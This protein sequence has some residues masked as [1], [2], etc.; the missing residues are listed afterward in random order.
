MSSPAGIVTP[1]ADL[2]YRNYDGPLENPDLRWWV[3]AKRMILNAIRMKSLWIVTVLSGWYFMIIMIILFFMQQLAGTSPQAASTLKSFLGRIIWKDQ[4]LHGFSFAQSLLL[5]IA[6]IFG[7]GA[8]AN[9]NRANALLVYLSKPCTKLDYVIGKWVG[10]FLI[11]LGVISV[12]C[13]VFYAYGAFSFRDQGFI[14]DDPW[15]I[16]RVLA[17]LPLSAALHTSLI[18][19]VSSLF[20]QGRMAGATYAG[21]YFL[22]NFF[23]VLMKMT[24]VMSDGA[25]SPIVKTLYYCSID[26]VQIGLAKAILHPVGSKPFGM[27]GPDPGFIPAP[28]LVPFLIFV[29]ALTVGCIGFVWSRIRAVEVV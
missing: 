6:L 18:L 14:K 16:F 22:S 24:W 11:L 29:I 23:T 15:L 28:A 19:A 4:F 20:R 3:I 25:A 9:D 5:V 13:L 1:I 2:S 10:L 7:A 8:I 17:I 26:G 12:P 21:L 27:P